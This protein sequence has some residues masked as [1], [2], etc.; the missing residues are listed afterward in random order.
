MSRAK[1]ERDRAG[2]RRPRCPCGSVAS[3]T[4]SYSR[5]WGYGRRGRVHTFR[6]RRF[7]SLSCF[8][9]CGIVKIVINVAKRG[10]LTL[11]A[12]FK[13]QLGLTDNNLVIAESAPEGVL[14]RPAVAVPIETYTDERVREFDE[15]E[16]ELATEFD[17]EV[18]RSG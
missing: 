7:T 3:V 2:R 6:K 16:A 4:P 11:R 18:E 13:K 17:S 9:Y 15:S 10:V 8:R 1:G 5:A 14:L 12:K